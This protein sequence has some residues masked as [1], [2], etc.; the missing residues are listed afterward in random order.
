MKTKNIVNAPVVE[1]SLKN[2]NKQETV[3]SYM[4]S[5]VGVYVPQSIK[6]WNQVGNQYE[7]RISFSAYDDKGNILEQSQ[8]GGVKEVYVWG[9]GRQYVLAKVLGSNSTA[10]SALVNQGILDGG[11]EADR[12]AQL[13]TLRN[14]FADNPDVQ[15]TTFTYKPLVGMTSQTDAKGMTTYY[16][17]DSF[18]RLKAV[19][20]QNGEILK[21]YCYNYAGQ[22]TDCNSSAGGT[23]QTPPSLVYARVEVENSAT[24]PISDG[25]S[26]DADIY[27]ALYSDV[28][29]TQPVSL[30]QSLDVN[31]R[32]SSS[33]YENNVYAGLNWTDTYT[34]PANTNRLYLGRFTTDWWYSYYDPYYEQIINSYYYYYQI[35][36]N[37]MN[38]YIPAATY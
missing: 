8:T 36:D 6:T 35:E 22:L 17:Y 3:N 32:T 12:Q 1:T 5:S 38:T 10:V 9:H 25:S 28:N 34:V 18:Q 20:N 15:V 7:D 37:G 31:M 2:N 16:E 29:C 4:Q 11:S 23:T 14:Y 13:L 30:P 27:I 26:T 33:S 19:K 21:T 24:N